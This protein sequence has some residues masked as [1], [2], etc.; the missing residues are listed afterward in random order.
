MD[1]S[2]LTIVAFGSISMVA[3]AVG[4]LLRDLVFGGQ[5]QADRKSLRR[6]QN[7]YDRPVSHSLSGK[8]DQG[9]DRLIIESGL[10]ISPTTG[11]M[12]LF[13]SAL[14]F[15]GGISIVTDQPLYGIG[16][17]IL[18]LILPLFIFAVKRRSRMHQIRQE[19]PTMI[20]IL[21][22]ATRTGQ[23]IEQAFNLAAEETSG[24]VSAELN[25]LNQSLNV[26]S[27]FDRSIKIFSRRLPLVEIR[28]LATTLMVQRQSGGHLS[29]TLERMSS[30][31]RDRISIQNQIRATT[32]AGRLST[33]V[34]AALAPAAF[35]I[36]MAVNPEH[37]DVLMHDQTGKYLLMLGVVL[38]VVGLLWVL[39][40][41][42][43]EN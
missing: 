7:V 15:G 17:A 2:E 42:R 34:I 21:A 22:R 35:L 9:F 36:I 24:I 40:L 31:I 11:F 19:L 25:R 6:S 26:G 20:D 43:N 23:S 30:V 3:T 18:G 38:E 5:N 16:G 10:E 14:V 27:S 13:A 39:L 1:S 37:V 4:L 33:A 28:I 41:M 8:I 12:I 32:G 29:E